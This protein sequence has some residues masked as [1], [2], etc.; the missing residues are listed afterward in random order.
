VPFLGYLPANRRAID[1]KE[2]P[3]NTKEASSL[4]RT[5]INFALPTGREQCILLTS[6]LP[7]EGKTTVAGIVA[8]AMARGGKSTILI[9]GDMRR[10]KIAEMFNVQ[11]DLPG[12]SNYLKGKGEMDEIVVRTHHNKLDLIVSGPPTSDS[13]DLLSSD[14]MKALLEK[15]KKKYDK[16]IIDTPPIMMGIPD[17]LLISK[18]VDSVV[19]VTRFSKTNRMLFQHALKHLQRCRAPVTGV[20]INGFDHSK[21]KNTPYQYYNSY[22]SYSLMQETN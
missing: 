9:S 14:R 3:S 17:T 13:S 6:P 19:L 5:S 20:I 16:I 1:V 22:Y 2:L 8:T 4:I 21:I 11:T 15:L 12:L 10:P 18:L 7:S